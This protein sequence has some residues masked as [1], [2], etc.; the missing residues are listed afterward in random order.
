[1]KI[2]RLLIVMV[3]FALLPVLVAC[4]SDRPAPAP[5]VQREYVKYSAKDLYRYLYNLNFE[6]DK[7]QANLFNNTRYK[8]KGEDLQVRYVEGERPTYVFSYSTHGEAARFEFEDE[9][10]MIEIDVFQNSDVFRNSFEDEWD[11]EEDDDLDHIGHHVFGIVGDYK[12]RQIYFIKKAERASK[13][14]AK[15]AAEKAAKKQAKKN[16]QVKVKNLS[17]NIKVWMTQLPNAAKAKKWQEV[18]S[19]V[20]KIQSAAREVNTLESKNGLK[21]SNFSSQLRMAKS[22]NDAA[23]KGLAKKNAQGK[24]KNLSGNIKVWMTQLP[25]AAKAKKWQEVQ[26]LV[27]KIQSAAREVNTLESKN[28]LKKSNF[29]SQLRT[30]KSA[31]DAAKKGLAKEQAKKDIAK[32]SSRVKSSVSDA[33]LKLRSKSYSG[34]K[35]SANDAKGAAEEVNRLQRQHGFAVTNF[36]N[37]ISS[38]NSVITKADKAIV[39]KREADAKKP[40]IKKK[41][42]KVKKPVRV[43]EPAK[44]KPAKK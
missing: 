38:A 43:Q 39:A 24:V 26:S 28:G 16:A 12:S 22:A 3:S 31:N 30:A 27:S 36:S 8:Y 41:P 5:V 21:K 35:A 29:S 1:M 42:V 19:L 25:N 23:K 15:L 9:G 14:A 17:G 6:V 10:D 37:F 18:Q 11:I 2:S 40:V 13:I 44:K 20:S 32:L 34:A 7:V 4:E 33:Q